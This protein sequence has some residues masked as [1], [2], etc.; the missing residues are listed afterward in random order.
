MEKQL[1]N[2]EKKKKAKQPSRPSSA[3]PGRVPARPRRLTGGI[4]LSA[5]TSSP[6]PPSLSRPLPS[7]ARLSVPV[8]PA[9]TPLSSL[10]LAGPACQSPSHCPTRPFSLSLCRGPSLSVP[11][12]PR[13][14]WTSE[15]ALA[16]VTGILGHVA[17]PTL[18]LVFEP[19]P[20]PHSLPRLISRCPALARALLTPP[21]LVEDPRPPPRPSSLPETTPS[22]PELRPEVRHPCPC[23]ISSIS[24]GHRPILASSE[25][26]HGG[27]SHPRGDRPN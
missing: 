27:T 22:H 25:L 15:C 13:P 14:P 2:L 8:S 23:L 4:H 6:A 16:H 5:S 17:L 21:D 10:C 1:E 19:R 11:P 9:R 20:C 26:G 18:Q 3:Q 24:L 7:G 12:S